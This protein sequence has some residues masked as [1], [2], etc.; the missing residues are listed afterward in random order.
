MHTKCSPGS[1]CT[2]LES[3]GRVTRLPNTV[4][5]CDAKNKLTKKEL[6]AIDQFVLDC[7]IGEE[8]ISGK[9]KCLASGVKKKLL[10]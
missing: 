2:K 5:I 9:N 8:E 1:I 10:F 7:L 3:D 4:Q 6:L